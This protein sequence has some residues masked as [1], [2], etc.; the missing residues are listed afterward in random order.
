MRVVV[1]EV[2]A[3]GQP[4]DEVADLR[5]SLDAEQEAM[6]FLDAKARRDAA[7][8]DMEVAKNRLIERIGAAGVALLPG[9][10]LTANRTKDTPDREAKQGEIIKGRRG[11]RRFDIKA[12]EA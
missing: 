12:L 5:E 11:Y 3:L 7:E 8:R 1:A 6:D 4:T 2:E 10:R 9:H